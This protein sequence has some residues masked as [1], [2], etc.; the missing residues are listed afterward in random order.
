[1][2]LGQSALLFD[3]LKFT[4]RLFYEVRAVAHKYGMPGAYEQI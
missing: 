1:M 3:S 4:D 2:N